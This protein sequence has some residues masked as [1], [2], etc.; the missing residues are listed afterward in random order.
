MMKHMVVKNKKINL[1]I[2]KNLHILIRYLK[3]E[4]NYKIKNIKSIPLYFIIN[5]N[6]NHGKIYNILHK[7]KNFVNLNKIHNLNKVMNSPK[8]NYKDHKPQ[9]KLLNTLVLIFKTPLKSNLYLNTK[10]INL[11]S[12][13]LWHNI[14]KLTKKINWKNIELSLLLNLIDIMEIITPKLIEII[15][16]Y[17]V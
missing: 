2:I 11:N 8:I 13:I 14:V 3:L 17:F 4:K 6:N 7:L 10:H 16:F 5:I 15:I 12:K 9:G 1:S